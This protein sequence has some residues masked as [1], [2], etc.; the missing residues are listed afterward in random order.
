MRY[1]RDVP[2]VAG[3]GSASRRRPHTAPHGAL[4]RRHFMRGATHARWAACAAAVVLAASG[5]GGDS[6]ASSDGGGVLSSSW[7]DPQNPLEPANTNEVQGGKVMEMLFRGLKRYNPRTGAAEN[8]IADS[9]E[10]K[11]SQHFTVKL[12]G[13][14]TFSNG[15]PVTA[16]SFVDA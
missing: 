1:E 13:G 8:V 4:R 15:E 14:W 10:T 5:C 7:G 16:K 9:I 2:I 12:K 11:D 3:N 6:S